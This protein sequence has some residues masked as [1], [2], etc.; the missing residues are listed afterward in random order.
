[1]AFQCPSLDT[2]NHNITGSSA[3]AL[4][5]GQLLRATSQQKDEQQNWNR[6][7]QQPKQNV[8]RRTTVLIFLAQAHVT[9]SFLCLLIRMRNETHVLQIMV[10]LTRCF[11]KLSSGFGVSGESFLCATVLL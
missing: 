8:P 10:W 2:E 5:N 6:N 7:S 3:A 1:M 11:A 9:R 4:Q